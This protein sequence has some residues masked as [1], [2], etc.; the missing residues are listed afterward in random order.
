MCAAFTFDMEAPFLID[1]PNRL[2][3][4]FRCQIQC[5]PMAQQDPATVIQV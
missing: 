1:A 4:W 2:G 3:G 5:W